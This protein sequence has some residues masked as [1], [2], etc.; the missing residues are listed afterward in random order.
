MKPMLDTRYWMLDKSMENASLS[1]S[2]Q[3]PESSKAA[4]LR[5]V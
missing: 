3:H 2:I 1:S 4:G 5:P